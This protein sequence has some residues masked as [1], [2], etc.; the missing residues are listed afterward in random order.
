MSDRAG[1]ARPA[2]REAAPDSAS[3]GAKAPARMVFKIKV[4]RALTAAGRALLVLLARTAS[5]TREKRALTA[6]GRARL[7]RNAQFGR[8]ARILMKDVIV[9]LAAE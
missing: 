9:I 4:K 7:V 5:R 6:A 2:A 1:T 8:I 3:G